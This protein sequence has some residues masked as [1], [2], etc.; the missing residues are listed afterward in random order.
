MADKKH[1]MIRKCRFISYRSNVVFIAK[2]PPVVID[3]MSNTVQ[4]TKKPRENAI[5][6]PAQ[7]LTIIKDAAAALGVVP[8]RLKCCKRDSLQRTARKLT[9]LVWPDPTTRGRVNA[10]TVSREKRQLIHGQ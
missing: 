1:S 7:C 2:P 9:F 10:K 5:P 3:W 4:Q 6:T 8:K